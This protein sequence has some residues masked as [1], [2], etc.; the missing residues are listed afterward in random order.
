L[1]ILRKRLPLTTSTISKNVTL[2]IAS[3][4]M[5]FEQ[6]YKETGLKKKALLRALAK[7]VMSSNAPIELLDRRLIRSIY[8][9]LTILLPHAQ[10]P[11]HK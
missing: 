9:T 6:A 4:K 11:P 5:T 1:E 3:D 10:N 8:D 2:T 7:A